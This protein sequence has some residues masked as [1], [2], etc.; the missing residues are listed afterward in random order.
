MA[1]DGATFVLRPFPT[2]QTFQNLRRTRQGVLHVTDDV[3]LLAQ[4]AV[5][6]APRPAWVPATQVQGFVLQDCCRYMEFVVR[7]LDESQE[8]MHLQCAVVHHA[9]RRDFFG[10]NRAKHAVVEAAIVATRLHLLPAAEVR[11]DYARWRVWVDKTGGPV[12]HAAFQFL[13]D[14]VERVLAGGTP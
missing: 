6:H 3:L 7:E 9:T 13:T 2:S 8:R 1:A 11:A 12:E 10:L 14:Y 4:A 5:G